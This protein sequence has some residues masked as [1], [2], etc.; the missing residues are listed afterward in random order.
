MEQL[1]SDI[2][3]PNA[4]CS[5]TDC[6]ISY[7]NQDY[8][9]TIYMSR[10]TAIDIVGDLYWRVHLFEDR[11]SKGDDSRIYVFT[12]IYLILGDLWRP[13]NIIYNISGG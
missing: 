1:Y 4:F 8:L 3:K 5:R 9:C 13:H 6:L 2:G 12:L 10:Y 7:L 11:K